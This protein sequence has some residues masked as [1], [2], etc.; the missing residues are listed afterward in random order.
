M[1][2]RQRQPSGM[3]PRQNNFG[4]LPPLSTPPPGMSAPR[5]GA[6]P[7]SNGPMFAPPTPFPS[8]LPAQPRFAS[9]Q[10]GVNPAGLAPAQPPRMRRN[11]ET[12]KMEVWHRPAEQRE[13][14][15]PA[16]AVHHAQVPSLPPS[17]RAGTRPVPAA[18][19]RP[20][21][22]AV[23]VP[24][25]AGLSRMSAAQAVTAATDP[26]ANQ[27]LPAFPAP[28]SA[29]F[30]IT[31]SLLKKYAGESTPSSIFGTTVTYLSPQERQQYKLTMHN[32]I[33][34][35]ADGKPFDTSD[36]QTAFGGKFATIVMDH[37][38][39]IYASKRQVT[40]KFHHSSFMAG[41]AVAMAGEMQVIKGKVTYI[42]RN[43]GHYCPSKLQLNQLADQLRSQGASDFYVDQE[44]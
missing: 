37:D 40:G 13:H 14:G 35:G 9:P 44:I 34:Y 3:A 38:G 28:A 20:E 4:M 23:L 31:S 36:A 24:P 43:S 30:Q 12:G 42:N 10:H 41:G 11:P 32:G 19:A 21:L 25:K 18:N 26:F 29:K 27:R 6:G 22:P 2:F 16:E 17:L 7:L 15:S 39:T 5:W 1:P 8:H 33:M